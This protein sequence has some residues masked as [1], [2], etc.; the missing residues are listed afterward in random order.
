MRSG[1][2]AV[3][4]FAMLA[5]TRVWAADDAGKPT[6]TVRWQ[7]VVSPTAQ[8]FPSLILATS[9]MP[10]DAGPRDG[11]V[12][13]DANG[14]IGARIVAGRDG[15]RVR[16]TVRI[17]GLARP[18]VLEATLPRHGRRYELLPMIL[19]DFRALAAVRQARPETISFELAVDGGKPEQRH[20]RV[21]VRGVNDAPYFVRGSEGEVDLAWMF[22]AYVNEDHPLVDEI[23]RQALATGVV[24]R[25]DGYQSGDPQ[26][27]YRQV[28]AIWYVLQQR[29]IRYSSIARTA[30]SAQAVLSQHVRFLDE[31]WQNN[32][33]NC[34]DGS[35]LLASVLRKI[36]LDPQLVLTPGHMLLGFSLD[37][38][39]RQRAYLE[40]TLLGAGLDA[41][42]RTD[43]DRSLAAFET[44][45]ERGLASFE[46]H[47]TR[48]D[49]PREA[50]YRI[51][52]IAAARRI[53]VAPI[54][55]R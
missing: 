40:T 54:S 51:V 8:L 43:E 15:Q 39:G 50:E 17:D 53:G 48:F 41:G 42:G 27:V 4:L 29:G 55:R 35:V 37:R 46:R 7:P 44:A 22:A 28:F 30:G 10:Q 19:W 23:L 3:F 26:A 25:F 20:Q 5:V 21:R 49:R 18:S 31:S 38:A 47:A 12:I 32:Q 16:L 24:R 36:D 52:D 11:E 6:A 45:V 1:W 2:V 34:V 33:A 13:G 9:T 14:M